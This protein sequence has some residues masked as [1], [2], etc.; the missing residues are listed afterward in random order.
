MKKRELGQQI[1]ILDGGFVYVAECTLADGFLMMTNARCIRKWGTT[2]GLG[3]LRSGPT[4]QT[5]LDVTGEI[6]APLGRVIHM[7]KCT[8]A[9]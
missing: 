5:V 4:S 9:W 6:V 8:A 7:I 1:V 3:E 2:S